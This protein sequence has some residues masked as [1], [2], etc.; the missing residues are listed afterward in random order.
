MPD[1][2]STIIAT[3][4]LPGERLLW[5]GRPKQGFALRGW[6]ILYLPMSISMVIIG[7]VLTVYEFQ[8]GNDSGVL[9]FVTIWTVGAFYFAFGRFLVDKWKRS[10]T[11]YALTNE[12]AII[13]TNKRSPSVQSVSLTT[14]KEI[15]ATRRADGTGTIEFDR[16]SFLSFRGQFDAG[17]GASWPFYNDLITPAFEMIAAPFEV[18]ELTLQARDEAQAGVK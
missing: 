7:S 8:T 18:R 17:R 13:L 10:N 16:P 15:T 12:R 4:L 6:D 3:H 5:A 11:Y 14:L 2:A 1:E 9:L